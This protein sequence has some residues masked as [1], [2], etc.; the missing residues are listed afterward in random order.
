MSS[1]PR[2]DAG[3]RKDLGEAARGLVAAGPSKVGVVKAM[4]ARDV[5]REP[6]GDP[7]DGARSGQEG[8]GASGSGGSSP[9]DS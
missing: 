8:A 9:E 7:Q 4:R 6:G 1:K 3:Q 2:P 5:S